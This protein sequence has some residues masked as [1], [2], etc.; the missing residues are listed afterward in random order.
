MNVVVK[1]I[2]KARRIE[3]IQMPIFDKYFDVYEVEHIDN[4]NDTFTTIIYSDEKP[5]QIQFGDRD[6]A[7][8]SLLEIVELNADALLTCKHMF[9][10]CVKLRDINMKNLDTRYVKDMEGMFFNCAAKRL[11]LSKFNT[12]KVTTMRNMFYCC[13]TRIIDCNSFDTSNVTDM[14][15]MFYSCRGAKAIKVDNFN[16]SKVENM[17]AMFY[18]CH[19]LVSL[20]LRSFD[21]NKVNDVKYMF[22]N[23]YDLEKL[24]LPEGFIRE[25]MDQTEMFAL[26]DKLQ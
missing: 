21:T 13:E 17:Q 4:E 6:K 24:M 22:A 3:Q 23:C 10:N 7:N 18:G 8:E 25:D 2:S 26:C 19:T 12:S 16:T 15:D 9:C 1:F 5:K 20:D 11:D 14:H